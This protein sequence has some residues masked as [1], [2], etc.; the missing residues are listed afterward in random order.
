MSF[1]GTIDYFANGIF[2]HPTMA[3][4]YKVAAFDGLN[5]LCAADEDEQKCLEPQ[6]TCQAPQQSDDN[7]HEDE[8]AFEALAQEALA[9]KAIAEE[10]VAV[11]PVAHGPVADE[12]TAHNTIPH[13]AV[14]D[15][16]R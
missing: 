5:R 11:E 8:C 7:Q 16:R 14:A 6:Q 4:S 12:T 13:E 9:I 3:E 2:N 1:D 10:A 15:D